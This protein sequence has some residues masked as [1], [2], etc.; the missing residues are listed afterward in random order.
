VAAVGLACLSAPAIADGPIGTLP[1]G[2]YACELPG[3]AAG[4]AGIAQPQAG[5]AIESSSRYAAPQGGGTYLRRGRTLMMTSG[6]RQGETY[7]IV[8]DGFLRRIEGDATGRL[9]CIHAKR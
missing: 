9:R 7:T 1:R 8:S 4:Q 2:A 5:F 6:P 3:D